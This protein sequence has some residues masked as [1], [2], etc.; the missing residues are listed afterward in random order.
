MKIPKDIA[1]TSF[2]LLVTCF[3]QETTTQG[4][5]TWI[6]LTKTFKYS[7]KKA[8]KPWKKFVMM[9]SLVLKI[10]MQAGKKYVQSAK[11]PQE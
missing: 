5:K 7:Q 6:W 11:T 10:R 3:S 2:K 1:S 4:E 9:M 8:Q